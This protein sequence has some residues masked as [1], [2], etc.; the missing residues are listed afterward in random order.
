MTLFEETI[1]S[2][3]SRFAA[4]KDGHFTEEGNFDLFWIEFLAAL[5]LNAVHEFGAFR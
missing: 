4:A 1:D 3:L 2:A 5:E